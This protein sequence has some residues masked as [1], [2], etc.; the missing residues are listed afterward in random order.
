MVGQISHPRHISTMA[1]KPTK[2][3][4]DGE[5]E[6]E[7][8]PASKGGIVGLL[9]NRIVLGVLG[10]AIIGGGGAFAAMKMGYLGGHEEGR[11]VRPRPRRRRRRRSRSRSSTC[12]R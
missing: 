2:P 5:E 9:K 4:A 10:L 3:G 7:A 12:R 11:R 6:G 8:K 1:K